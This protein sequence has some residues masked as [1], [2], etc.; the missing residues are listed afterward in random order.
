MLE[1]PPVVSTTDTRPHVYDTVASSSFPAFE[2]EE[3]FV[4]LENV[5]VL[6]RVRWIV[7][8]PNTCQIDDAKRLLPHGPCTLTTPFKTKPGHLH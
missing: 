2:Q 6:P 8:G 3:A 1:Y 5:I 7:A 4:S